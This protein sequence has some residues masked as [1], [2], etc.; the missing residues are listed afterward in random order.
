MTWSH[1]SPYCPPPIVLCEPCGRQ[2]ELCE[3]RE[4]LMWPLKHYQTG[5]LGVSW[6]EPGPQSRTL[7]RLHVDQASESLS[8]GFLTSPVYGTQ[9]LSLVQSY[10]LCGAP[11][12]FQLGYLNHRQMNH[13]PQRWGRT[14]P[15]GFFTLICPSWDQSHTLRERPPAGVRGAACGY[16]TKY[17]WL[18]L[19]RLQA[20]TMAS[21]A[22]CFDPRSKSIT[23]T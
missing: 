9:A 12:F 7:Q 1:T 2:G 20:M 3:A 15:Y 22:L 19:I 6:E 23:N 5:L 16:R 10:Y 13:H 4:S 21:L 17:I 11:A 18:G 14:L 8:F